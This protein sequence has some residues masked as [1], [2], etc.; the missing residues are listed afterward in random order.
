[1]G[2][3]VSGDTRQIFIGDSFLYSGFGGQEAYVAAARFDLRRVPRGAPILNGT[4]RLSG[5]RDNLLN[6]NANISWLVQLI[7][8]EALPQL[9]GSDFT[10]V[11]VAPASIT[12]SPQLGPSD[13]APGTVNEWTLDSNARSW[14]FQ[15]LIDGATSV[16]V[17]IA[18]FTVGADSL[19]AWD[20]GI[21]SESGGQAPTLVLRVG[22]PPPT[23]PPT[24]THPVLVATLTSEPEN[25][26]TVVA[27]SA[28]A[29]A[30]GLVSGTI[31]PTPV[32]VITPTPWPE[33]LATVQAAAIAADFPPV[34]LNTPV[35]ANAA[36]ASVNAEFATAVALTT[37]TFTPVP[38]NY[39]TPALYYPPP[40]PENVATAAARA[41]RATAAAVSGVPTPTRMWN[42]VSAIYVFATETPANVETAI[43]RLEEQNLVAATTG[44][45][46]PTPWNLVIITRVPPPAPTPIPLVV[47][48]SSITPTPT[49]T[50]TREFT[51]GDF[52]RF[53]NKIL[54]LSDRSGSTQTWVLDPERGEVIGSVT[55]NQV[56]KEA[57]EMFLPSSPDG[58]RRVAV[59]PDSNRD[60]Q[61]NVEDSEY[62][63]VRQL[64]SFPAATSYDPAWSPGGDWIAFVST[65]SGGDEIYVVSPDGED[66][67][68]LTFNSWEWDKHPSWSPDGSEIVFFSNRETGR[69]QLWI[70][71]ATGSD[72]RNLSNNE[73]SDWD[74]VWVR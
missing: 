56:H 48:I 6:R 5:L 30:E 60:L 32:L 31:T 19:F 29:T 42:A 58:K 71:N 62:G 33:N 26:L 13:V 37:G 25:V 61:I 15:Q 50:P 18:P 72:Q 8:E 51:G 57:R 46:T 2:W 12:L 45:P 16:V 65:E 38:T 10:T 23:P 9:P 68:R 14:I 27:R 17:R 74:P 34:V 66:P 53:R 28:T 21:G 67:K 24:P 1:M 7:A 47:P 41:L 52:E 40:P 63:T 69:R 55:D 39:V 3:W 43:A 44:T 20:S 36:T 73:Y 54:F 49:P 22:A 4:L 11:F 59:H 64:T 35:P 70:M